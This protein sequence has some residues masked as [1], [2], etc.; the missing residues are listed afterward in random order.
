LQKEIAEQ[1]WQSTSDVATGKI[2]YTKSEIVKFWTDFDHILEFM[3]DD[4][5]YHSEEIEKRARGTRLQRA[6]K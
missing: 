2:P 1:D 6:L 3:I 5:R 4:V